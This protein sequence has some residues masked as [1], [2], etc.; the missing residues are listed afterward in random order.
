MTIRIVPEA[1]LEHQTV[2]K[3]DKILCFFCAKFPI[4]LFNIIMV[5]FVRKK[6]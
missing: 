4:D 1:E 6:L 3:L 5:N 2:L